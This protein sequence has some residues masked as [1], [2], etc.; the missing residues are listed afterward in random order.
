MIPA[1]P[2]KT[3]P[4]VPTLRKSRLC[5]SGPPSCSKCR[6]SWAARKTPSFIAWQMSVVPQSTG[7]NE[8][9][10]I[11]IES[12]SYSEGP[13][14]TLRASRGAG[15]SSDAA[16][17]V[18]KLLLTFGSDFT[19]TACCGK[20][21]RSGTFATLMLAGWLNPAL[22]NIC[23]S[24]TRAPCMRIMIEAG[25]SS[26]WIS[27]CSPTRRVEYCSSACR[28]NEMS[29]GNRPER[30]TL[31]HPLA[32]NCQIRN[33]CWAPMTPGLRRRLKNGCR[34]KWR[35]STWDKAAVSLRSGSPT[36]SE[37]RT[38]SGTKA[39]CTFPVAESGSATRCRFV[40]SKS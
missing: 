15:D 37:S 7:M 2:I 34:S 11:R 27:A 18:P 31:P 20:E 24:N 26:F 21:G 14:R 12:L 4:K 25:A 10:R 3:P 1:L 32:W 22:K 28:N 19:M 40:R 23:S 35:R 13:I 5:G 6:R 29:M 8:L 30:P 16:S 36:A 17:D 9:P 39:T 38:R 33:W